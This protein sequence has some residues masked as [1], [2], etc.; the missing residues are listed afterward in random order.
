MMSRVEGRKGESSRGETKGN[1]SGRERKMA[2]E[3]STWE[4]EEMGSET[5]GEGK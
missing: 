4:S 2:R 1:V 3:R 5:E